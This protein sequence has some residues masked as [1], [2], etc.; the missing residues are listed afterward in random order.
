MEIGMGRMGRRR[1]M[2]GEIIC[3]FARHCQSRNP[4]QWKEVR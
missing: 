2:L 1:G 4:F 3:V